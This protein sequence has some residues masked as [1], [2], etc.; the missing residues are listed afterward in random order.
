MNSSQFKFHA[1]YDT[2]VI[3]NIIGDRKKKLGHVLK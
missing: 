3:I 2:S 1:V